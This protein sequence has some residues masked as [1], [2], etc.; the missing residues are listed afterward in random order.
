[1]TP[2]A[3]LVLMLCS[4]VA[5]SFAL[6]VTTSNYSLSGGS[7][8]LTIKNGTTTQQTTTTTY[9]TVSTNYYVDSVVLTGLQWCMGDHV[10]NGTDSDSFMTDILADAID[11]GGSTESSTTINSSSSTTLGDLYSLHTAGYNIVVKQ[12]RWVIG[13]FNDE[14]SIDEANVTYAGSGV[15]TPVTTTTTTTVATTGTA[16][17]NGQTINLSS[18][19]FGSSSNTFTQNSGYSSIAAISGAGKVIINGGTV[20]GDYL[21]G[22]T[23]TT[24]STYTARELFNP[25][26]TL[27]FISYAGGTKGGAGSITSVGGYYTIGSATIQVSGNYSQTARNAI[28]TALKNKYGSSITVSFTGSLLTDNQLTLSDG[29]TLSVLNTVFAENGRGNYLFYDKNLNAQSSDLTINTYSFGVKNVD[30]AKTITATNGMEFRVL[31]ENASTSI[32]GAYVADAGHISFGDNVVASGGTAGTVSVKNSG[33]FSVYQTG[34]FNLSTLNLAGTNYNFGTLNLTNL[35]V[36]GSSTIENSGT[37]RLAGGLTSSALTLKNHNSFTY[38]G[39]DNSRL[40]ALENSGTAS[41]GGALTVTGNLNNS[42]ASSVLSVAGKLTVEGSANNA[43][44]VSAASAVF[45]DLVNSG[46]I[47]AP[48][49]MTVTGSLVNHGTLKTQNV[50]FGD[51]S[52]IHNAGV[53]TMGK[54]NGDVEVKNSGI[55]V[56]DEITASIKNSGTLI[57]ESITTD[58]SLVVTGTLVAGS[59]VTYGSVKRASTATIVQG[60]A[61]QNNYFLEHLD[62]ARLFVEAGG[63]VS[64]AVLDALAEAEAAGISVASLDDG[65][66]ESEQQNLNNEEKE[67]TQPEEA[68]TT[69]ENKETDEK[70]AAAEEPQ[71]ALYILDSVDKTSELVLSR[72]AS[73]ASDVYGLTARRAALYEDKAVF[74]KSGLWLSPDKEKSKFGAYKSDRFGFTVGGRHAFNEG[75]TAL[76]FAAFYSKGKLKGF[77]QN[78]VEGYGATLFGAQ[79]FGAGFVAGTAS[80]SRDKTKK[81]KSAGLSRL[82]ATAASVS[83]KAGLALSNKYITFTPYAG[84]RG[85]YLSTARAESA[86]S[87]QA[88]AGAKVLTR[89]RVGDWKFQPEAD[90][91]Y[92][93]QMKDR[94]LKLKYEDGNTSVFAG[95]NAVQGNLTASVTRRNVT[96]TLRYTG[97]AG[98]KGY[99]SHTLG[100]EFNYRF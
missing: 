32:A 93:R 21:I 100:A 31:G 96:A 75:A 94:V 17:N 29:W 69:E 7:Y 35:A 46:T 71:I 66:F 20:N 3:L 44:V 41:L 59:L 51:S 54:I 28:T 43:G 67:V 13:W 1:M 83:A 24:Y 76:G 14:D 65:D 88:A 18:L 34:T 30:N 79:R 82:T 45:N 58:E 99:R 60:S 39:T 38:T 63:T 11:W 42:N 53:L 48:D 77:A 72:E 12:M 8:A 70:K 10:E 68:E 81:Q 57:A 97:A 55:L 85:I 19:T 2:K 64:Q 47:N 49:G 91:S 52:E 92:A 62:E 90:L 22:R 98:D 86:Q 15:R 73:L 56:A 80:V 50:D 26:T 4:F 74:G 61:A 23:Q 5:P 37:Y 40:A 27:N 78:N 25:G 87:V 16:I 95:N 9:K 89:I 84:V 33:I 6:D 36:D